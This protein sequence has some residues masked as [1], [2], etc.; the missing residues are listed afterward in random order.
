MTTEEKKTEKQNRKTKQIQKK[1]NTEVWR[2]S[3]FQ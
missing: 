1:K 3:R 2:A